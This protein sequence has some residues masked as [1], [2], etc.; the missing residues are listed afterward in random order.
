M[1]IPASFRETDPARLHEFI[2]QHSFGILLTHRDAESVASHLPFVLDRNSGTQ[3]TLLGHVARA[4]D[5]WKGID[6][7]SVLVVFHGPH[8]YISPQWYEATNVV[9]TWNYVAV[10]VYGRLRLL[11]DN[12][13]ALAALRRTVAEYEPDSPAGWSINEPDAEF[14]EGL[15]EAIVGFEIEIERIEGKW[16]LSQNHD[17]ERRATVVRALQE[18]GGEQREQIAELMSKACRAKRDR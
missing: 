9:P 4:N 2:E 1:Y 17:K 15:L 13:Q 3:G 12:S 8:A 6:G 10:H 7:S 18:A 14:V 5:Q 16:K 11:A